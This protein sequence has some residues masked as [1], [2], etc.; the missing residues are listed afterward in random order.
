VEPV[1]KDQRDVLEVVRPPVEKRLQT[2]G[3]ALSFL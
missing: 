1:R 3:Q 2:Q